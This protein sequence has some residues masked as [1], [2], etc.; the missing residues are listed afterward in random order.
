MCCGQC[1][2]GTHLGT[3]HCPRTCPV[4]GCSVASM[5]FRGIQLMGLYLD[6]PAS[7]KVCRSRNLGEKIEFADVLISK[8]CSLVSLPTVLMDTA[9]G[10][11]P[12]CPSN[13]QE[14]QES[15]P[16]DISP[17]RGSLSLGPLGSL[18]EPLHLCKGCVSPL[19]DEPPCPSTLCHHRYQPQGY[20]TPCSGRKQALLC[21]QLRKDTSVNKAGD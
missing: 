2:L 18:A 6:L 10:M 5:V 15:N 3:L 7:E 4:L 12:H 19:A 8:S 9:Y 21:L 20:P 11:L 16:S 13:A 14:T 1:W 17:S